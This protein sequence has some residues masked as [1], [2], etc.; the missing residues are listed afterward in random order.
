MR[1][2]TELTPRQWQ[3]GARGATRGNELWGDLACGAACVPIIRVAIVALLGSTAKTV[4]ADRDR[5]RRA[6]GRVRYASGDWHPGIRAAVGGGDVA[7]TASRPTVG[8]ERHGV[9]VRP[10]RYQSRWRA[11]TL[12]RAAAD[13]RTTLIAACAGLPIISS[14]RCTAA[15]ITCRCAKGNTQTDSTTCGDPSRRKHEELRNA[16]GF[17]KSPASVSP[18][19]LHVQAPTFLA[20]LSLELSRCPRGNEGNLGTPQGLRA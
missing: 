6:G 10:E 4:A 7:R 8:N 1:A 18:V 2:V 12:P 15:R 16:I 14:T 13:S 20:N 19:C 3:G 11:P 17:S 5:G 9:P